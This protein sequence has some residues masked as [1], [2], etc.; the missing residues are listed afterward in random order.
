MILFRPGSHV[1]RLCAVLAVSGEIPVKSL[2][3]LGNQRVCRALVAKLIEPQT[4]LNSETG[5]RLTCRLLTL[6]GKG[7]TKAVRFYKTG[8]PVLDWIGAR[9]YYLASHWAHNYPSDASHVERNYRLAEAVAMFLRAGCEVCPWNMHRL[10]HNCI[11]PLSFPR[12]SFYPA[13]ELKNVAEGDL[14]KAQYARLIGAVFSDRAVM[15]VYNTRDSLMKWNGKGEFRAQQSILELARMNTE[16]KVIDAAI[17]LGASDDVAF[18]TVQAMEKAARIDLRFDTVY[19][20][21]YYVP[22]NDDGVRQLRLLLL[23]DWNE[24]LLDALFEPAIRSYG[25][26]NFEYD[27]FAGNTYILSFFDGDVSRLLHFLE[28]A[29][30]GRYR[31]EIVCFPHQTDL[32]KRLSE[33]RT[34]VRT[35]ESSVIFEALG[36]EGGAA[37]E[38]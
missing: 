13:R 18:R 32:V 37:Y 30:P 23:P 19:R 17:L 7:P 29:E 8:L 16:A 25:K 26:G 24:R 20:H 33:G 22:M 21:I 34:S 2:Y 35:F 5:E 1:R 36:L 12:P 4:L 3:L 15:I 10:Q 11:S 14:K 31:Y 27:A 38:P 28:N 6:H 9:E